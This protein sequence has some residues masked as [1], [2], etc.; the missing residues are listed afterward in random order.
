MNKAG[1]AALILLAAPTAGAADV[2]M[3]HHNTD[4]PIQVAADQFTADM[5]SKSGTYSG[6]VVVTQA[7]FKL[8]ANTVR[9]NI[10]GSKPDK[11][12]ANGTVVFSSP[13][14]IATGDAAVY[15]VGPRMITFTGRVVLTKDKNVMRGS[16]LRVNLVT[17]QAT[18]NAAGSKLGGGRVQGIFTPPPQSNS[19]TK[20]NP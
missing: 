11:I 7:D 9:V 15:D 13:S 10:I 5:N 16:N 12:V 3:G 4:A 17:G 20:P 19:G 6:N 18:L 2:N 1:I 14:G 8:R